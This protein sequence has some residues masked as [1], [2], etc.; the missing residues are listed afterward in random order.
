MDGQQKTLSESSDGIISNI[1]S[2][3]WVPAPGFEEAYEV[4]NMGRVRS[5]TR[6]VWTYIKPGRILK[7]QAKENG[8]LNVCL[9][10]GSKK[11]KHA[12]IHRLVAMAFLPNLDNLAEV[13]HKNFNKQDN[14]VDNLEW[15]SS[16]ENKAHFRAGQYADQK[17]TRTLVNKSI[18]YIIDY[19]NDVLPLYDTGIS[20]KEVSEK[21]N[22]GRDMVRDILV[23]YGRL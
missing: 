6:R 11:Q 16:K 17:K 14:R 3:V 19:K 20:I 9:S 8:Y 21:V 15:C 18:Q 13:N 23:I 22:I 4:S 7:P 12:Y 10:N 1:P 5:R 2:E